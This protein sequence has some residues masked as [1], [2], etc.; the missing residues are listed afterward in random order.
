MVVDDA[1]GLHPGINDRRAD[2]LEAAALQLLGD[3]L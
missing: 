2:E 1:D 3:S